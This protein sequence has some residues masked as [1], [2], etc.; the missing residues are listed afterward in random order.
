[1]EILAYIFSSLS[2][3]MSALFFIRQKVSIGFL[4]LFPKLF[5]GSLSPYWAITGTVGAIL[6]WLYQAY[7]AVPMGIISAVWMALYVWR[8]AR[9][10]YG[11]EEAFGEDWADQIHPEQ[12][13]LMAPKRWSWFLKLKSDPEPI[14]ERDIPFWT[15]PG[16]DRKLLCDIWRPANGSPSGLAF[17]FLHGS[18]WAMGDKDLGTRYLFSHLAGQ[19]HTVMDIAYRLIPEVDIYGMVGDAKRAVAWIKSNADK[20]GVNPEKIVLGGGSAGAHIALLAGY[21]PQHP[22]FTPEDLNGADL[23]VCGLISYYGT[24]DLLAG[25]ERYDLEIKPPV[26][27]GTIIDP[28]DAINFT[29]RLDLLLGGHPQDVPEMYQLASPATHV[30][31]GSPPTLHMQGDKDF[32]T[33]MVGIEKLHKNLVESGVPVINVVYPW[34]DHAFDLLFPQI[35]PP[36][37]SALYDVDRF[38][39]LMVN[40][41][42]T[43]ALLDAQEDLD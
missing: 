38:L 16:T 37:Q 19:G 32:L 25:Y 9:G 21:T 3:L 31:V 43:P 27:I 35:S 34:T 2:L 4:V 17:I 10:H 42:V 18:G 13:N 20:Y 5:A 22:K 26:P 14:W 33:P 30:G 15:I 8:I 39:G 41:Q 1:M 6:G 24:T 36:A 40:K 12:K 7:W 29:G 28:K 11:F 23:S